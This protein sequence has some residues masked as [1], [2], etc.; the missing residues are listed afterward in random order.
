MVELFDKLLV[1]TSE[2][3]MSYFGPM[4]RSSLREIFLGADGDDGDGDKGSIADLV[5]DASLD[6]TGEKENSIKRRYQSSAISKSC[7]AEIA[8]LR[9]DAPNG[10][11]VLDLLPQEEYPNSFLYRFKIVSERRIKLIGR[12]AVTWTRMFIAVLFG[13][14]IGSLFANTPNNLGGALAKVKICH[15]C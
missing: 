9:S 3:E 15:D 5:L 7:S 13:V 2:G 14:V 10:T 12:N 8:R 11:D 6:K 4:D 1:L